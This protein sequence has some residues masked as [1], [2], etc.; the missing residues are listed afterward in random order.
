[1]SSENLHP[2]VIPAPQDQGHRKG[3]Y[4][5]AFLWP[6]QHRPAT[7]P[8]KWAMNRLNASACSCSS[9]ESCGTMYTCVSRVREKTGRKS[10]KMLG[11][12]RVS[13]NV[14]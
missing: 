2:G 1:M 6:L 11:R 13:F 7:M 10:I 4:P 5:S 3:L 14:F 12:T 9:P 8:C